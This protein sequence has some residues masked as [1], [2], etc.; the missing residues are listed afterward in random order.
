MTWLVGAGSAEDLSKWVV[1]PEEFAANRKYTA[2]VT[3][4]ATPVLLDLST[5]RVLVN[6][7]ALD[8]KRAKRQANKARASGQLCAM[9][10]VGDAK[11]GDAQGA[12]RRG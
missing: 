11:P 5:G 6:A 4:D 10:T 1:N 8:S 9:Q 7:E 12:S 3:A 2:I